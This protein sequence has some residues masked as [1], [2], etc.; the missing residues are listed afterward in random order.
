MQF[1]A[2]SSKYYNAHKFDPTGSTNRPLVVF[3]VSFEF[4]VIPVLVLPLN[5]GVDVSVT[6]IV[7][8]PTN[9]VVLLA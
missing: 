3:R 5:V 7:L 9:T 2:I 6:L 1:S 8:L 4:A